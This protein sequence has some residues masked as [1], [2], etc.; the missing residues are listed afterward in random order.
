MKVA[1][2]V[3]LSPPDREELFQ[4]VRALGYEPEYR[5]PREERTAEQVWDAVLWVRDHLAPGAALALGTTVCPL[6]V[7]EVPAAG[8]PSR[9]CP[10]AVRSRR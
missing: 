6:G 10:R 2:E 3:V 8:N 5:A 1:V 7:E 9:I 4:D